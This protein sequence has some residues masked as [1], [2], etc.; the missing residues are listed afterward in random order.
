M[1]VCAKT[2]CVRMCVT[3]SYLFSFAKFSVEILFIV[4]CNFTVAKI[5]IAIGS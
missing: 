2:I 3:K 5:K 1:C 4:I